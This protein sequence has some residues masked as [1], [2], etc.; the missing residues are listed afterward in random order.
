MEKSFECAVICPPERAS[1]GATHPFSEQFS[2]D[3]VPRLIKAH[4]DKVFALV[5]KAAGMGR[6]KLVVLPEDLHNIRGFW[7]ALDNP[8]LF[9]KFA[10][11]IPGAATARACKIARK[12]KTNL[13][14]TLYE[15]TRHHLFNTTVFINRKGRITAKY[16]K[17]HLAPGE[18]W[19]VS[20]GSDFSVFK[21]DLGCMGIACGED[22]LFPETACVLARLGAEIVVVPSRYPIPEFVLSCRSYE[23]GYVT[24]MANPSE[25]CLIDQAG[26][27]L[28]HNAG[29]TDYIL[30]AEFLGDVTSTDERDA[31][32]DILM[33][34]DDR[35]TRQSSRRMPKAYKILTAKRWPESPA[36][37]ERERARYKD[38]IF[39]SL[40][41]LNDADELPL[42][43]W[44]L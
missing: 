40:C 15:R 17:I 12:S 39:R 26:R 38:E 5:E 13:V 29:R 10:E 33:R 23:L 43:E 21:T 41:D 35:R 2:L 44:D 28:T 36:Y 16:R 9:R 34:N 42:P 18:D 22:Y 31:L 32:D 19:Q 4:T 20:P 25:S 11:P 24:V 6:V 7:M 30:T 14:M 27:V 3:E 37:T 8:N 1:P